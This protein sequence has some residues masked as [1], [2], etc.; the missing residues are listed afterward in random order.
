MNDIKFK[1]NY[2]NTS[3]FQDNDETTTIVI[4][5]RHHCKTY[6]LPCNSMN[7]HFCNAIFLV[8]DLP[9]VGITI[10]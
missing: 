7:H 5:N 3:T 6:I 10:S 1:V 9:I 8:Q 2:V 4:A